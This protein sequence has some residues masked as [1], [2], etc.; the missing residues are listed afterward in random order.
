MSFSNVS[1]F[2]LLDWVFQVLIYVGVLCPFL[3]GYPLPS[4]H[5]PV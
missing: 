1:I 5:I 4:S 2:G 3:D